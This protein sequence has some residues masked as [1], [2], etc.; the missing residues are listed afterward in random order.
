MLKFLG[1]QS[2]ALLVACSFVLSPSHLFAAPVAVRHKEGVAHGFLVL[3]AR[4][5]KILA[6]GDMTQV[7]R[8]DQVTVEFTLR[9]KDGSIH[10]E[11]T[12]YSQR[13]SL[14]LISDHL[15]QKGPSFPHPLEVWVDATKGTVVV[16]YTDNGKEKVQTEKLDIPEDAANGLILNLLKNIEPEATQTTVSLV[17]ATPK[18]RIVKLVISS[19][20]Q[21]PFSVAGSPRKATDFVIKIDIGGVA[22]VVAPIVGKQPPDTHVWIRGGEAPVIV[23]FEGA[24]YEGGPIWRVEPASLAWR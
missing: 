18:P 10:D 22:G 5:G 2:F 16:H 23:G 17:A 6:A 7:T 8:D 1:L 20:G 12:V 4:S 3:R 11:T 21:R 15:V 13:Q 9:F 19:N 14:R 24:L